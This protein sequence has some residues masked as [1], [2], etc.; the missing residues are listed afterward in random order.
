MPER[1]A[2]EPGR[3]R[4]APNR[5]G[6]PGPRQEVEETKLSGSRR[7]VGRAHSTGEALEQARDEPTIPEQITER[8]GS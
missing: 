2:S 1:N 4:L 7:G 5:Q 3:P 8:A 6:D